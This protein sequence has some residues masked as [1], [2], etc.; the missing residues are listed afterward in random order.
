MGLM[1][2]SL[3]LGANIVPIFA[4]YY[5]PKGDW[6]IFILSPVMQHE[7]RGWMRKHLLLIRNY[8]LEQSFVQIPFSKVLEIRGFYEVGKCVIIMQWNSQIPFWKV[9]ASI[10]IKTANFNH[11]CQCTSQSIIFTLP[12]PPLLSQELIHCGT[13]I[14]QN[15]S[16]CKSKYCMKL[17]FRNP[18]VKILFVSLR[19]QFEGS[20]PL[21][22]WE[23]GTLQLFER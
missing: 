4:Y 9:S 11:E 3:S 15:F 7:W 21:K 18:N 23:K 20:F 19:K 22:V 1:P 2:S 6:S 8:V 12:V 10:T 14:S 16:F 17:Y 5:L 13:L